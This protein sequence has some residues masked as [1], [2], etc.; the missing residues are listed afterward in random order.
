M[1]SVITC[2]GTLGAAFLRLPVVVAGAGLLV[3]VGARRHAQAF[4]AA[5]QAEEHARLLV[6]R[7]RAS[8][9]AFPLTLCDPSTNQCNYPQRQILHTPFL[10]SSFR[11]K[12]TSWLKLTA[13]D[14]L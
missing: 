2:S 3:A 11:N 13:S 1:L 14:A 10:H 9:R 7:R 6:R 8:V 12:L 4:G 5:L